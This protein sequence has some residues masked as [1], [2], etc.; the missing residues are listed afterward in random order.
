[1]ASTMEFNMN[2]Y[3]P[4][5]LNAPLMRTIPLPEVREVPLHTVE[6]YFHYYPSRGGRPRVVSRRRRYRVYTDVIINGEHVAEWESHAI[7]WNSIESI[8]FHAL[9]DLDTLHGIQG[10]VTVSARVGWGRHDGNVST[11]RITGYFPSSY[12]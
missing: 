4:D 5:I 3:R 1:M 2:D 12:S 10:S 11:Y 6:L 9:D 8:V 7:D